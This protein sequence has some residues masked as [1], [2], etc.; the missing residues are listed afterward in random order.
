MRIVPFRI[1]DRHT[2]S[3]IRR[4]SDRCKEFCSCFTEKYSVETVSFIVMH[5]LPRFVAR[6]YSIS[7][8]NTR[9][10]P[11]QIRARY[12][13]DIVASNILP[14]FTPL[15]SL[16]RKPVRRYV[17]TRSPIALQFSEWLSRNCPFRHFMIMDTV[18]TIHRI[19]NITRAGCAF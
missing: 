15:A 1:P 4:I 3:I 8:H 10:A 9:R 16:P 17:A 5:F 6:N 14:K 18:F 19:R 12:K 7:R 13:F 2:Y 11:R